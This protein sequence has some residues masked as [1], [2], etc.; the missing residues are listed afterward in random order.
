MLIAQVQKELLRVA[1]KEDKTVKQLATALKVSKKVVED[2]IEPLLTMRFLEQMGEFYSTTD[3]G[4]DVAVLEG[5]E[6]PDN[7]LK[8][9]GKA[10]KA[11]KKIRIHR[12]GYAAN[13]LRE[14]NR[15]KKN[16]EDS[17]IDEQAAEITRLKKLL[18]AKD[19]EEEEE[20]EE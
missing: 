3:L 1:A 14:R 13:I 20:E 4:V 7:L 18:A 16:K 6:I 9:V 12:P 5:L 15:N 8:K 17:L 10:A 2:S 19:V 11:D